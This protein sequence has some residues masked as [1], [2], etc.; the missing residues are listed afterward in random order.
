MISIDQQELI[1][2]LTSPYKPTYL[3]VF[4]SFARGEQDSESDLDILVDFEENLDLLELIGLEQK[5]SEKLNLK[6]DLITYRS[7]NELIKPYIE[8]DLIQIF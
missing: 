6:V 3:G 4:G 8:K 5:L 1:K 2:E 7:L